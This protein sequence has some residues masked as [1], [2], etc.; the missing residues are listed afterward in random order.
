MVDQTIR[1]VNSS[2]TVEIVEEHGSFLLIRAAP[3]FAVLERRNGR[4]YPIAQGERQGVPMTAEA[5][6]A[7]L[8]EQGCLPK[9]EARRLFVELSERGERLLSL[10]DRTRGDVS[11]RELA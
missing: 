7:R 1:D 6:S 10:C 4:I 3:G 9:D 11:E 8:A 5:V 2:K